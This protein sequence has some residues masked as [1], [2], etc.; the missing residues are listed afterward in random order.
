M[1]NKSEP[2]RSE[3]WMVM[4]GP[5]QY[6]EKMPEMSQIVQDY[7]ANL[8]ETGKI[9]MQSYAKGLKLPEDYFTQH[10]EKPSSLLRLIKYPPTKGEK[11][12][13]GEHS[14]YGFLTLID[15]DDVGGLQCKTL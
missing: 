2:D 14:D 5:N 7:M 9:I 4:R 11:I 12:G 13:I 6:P 1:E 15:Q 10:F 3:P 8:G